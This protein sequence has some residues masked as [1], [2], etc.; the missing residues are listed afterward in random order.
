MRKRG[1]L[2]SVAV[3]LLS[4]VAIVGCGSSSSSSSSSSSATSSAAASSSSS[5]AASGSNA[6]IVALVPSSIKSKAALT[7]AADASYALS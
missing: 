5:S 2:L 1:S 6:S 3:T 4:A 7:V